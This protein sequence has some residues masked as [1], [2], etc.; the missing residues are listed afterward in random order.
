MSQAGLKVNAK[1]SFFAK[2][3]LEYLGYWVTR[4]GIQPVKSKVEAMLKVAP[5]KTKKQL[6][7]FI[8]L[9]NYYRDMWAKRSHVL[10]PLAALTSNQAKW[11]WKEEH[12]K[13]FNEVKKI[14]AK[15]VLLTFPDFNKPFDV[16]TD[17]SH[18]QLG[19]VIS[20]EGKPIA[21]YSRKLNPAQTRYTTTERELLSIVETLKEFKNILLGHEIIVHTDHKNLTYK[22]FNTERVMR[23]R[24]ILEEF[25]LTLKYIKGENNVV[26]DA[27]SRLEKEQEVANTLCT[28]DILTDEELE[29]QYPDD[30]ADEE[31]FAF[32]DDEQPKNYPLNYTAI[33]AGQEKDKKLQAQYRKS[34][35]F[36]KKDFRVGE[37]DVSLIVREGKICVP[38]NLQ[39]EATVWYH[40]LLMHSGEK[41]TELTVAQHYY[42]KHLKETVQDVCS[43]CDICQKTKPKK[44]KLGEVPP[45]LDIES[46]PWER[47]CIDLIGP[48]QF[49]SKEKGTDVTLHCLTMIDP[50]TGLFEIAEIPEKKADV[51]ANILE[52]TWLTRYPWPKYVIAD[53]GK[54]FMREVRDMLRHDYNISRRLITTRN[55]QANSMCERAHKT[56]HAMIASKQIRDVTDLDEKL[57]WEGILAAVRFAMRATV[58]TTTNATPSQLVFNRDAIHNVGFQ[59]NWQ[60]IRQRKQRLILQNNKRENAG[61]VPYTYKP[62]DRVLVLE[63]PKRKYGPTDR[64]SGPYTVTAVKDNGTAVVQQ[65]TPRGGVRSQTWNIRNLH[66]YKA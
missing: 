27:L 41:R 22:N 5:P 43:K 52:M 30:L 6:R 29:D 57:K 32:E 62:G 10:A 64:Y 45:K 28:L 36:T 34:K 13:V 40:D 18:Y 48:Y 11:E 56:L 58:H 9:V 51:I 54:E 53:R 17:A 44:A 39:R 26:A 47:L 2:S 1:K 19:V 24:L 60:Y 20:Q 66:P 37:R 63:D 55:P 25:G 61:R 3:E 8:G 12:Q 38:E 23:W 15:E 59:A 33:E 16:H 46:T 4:D 35:L 31:M 21:F 14:I 42:W 65:T 7:G 50:A 49:G